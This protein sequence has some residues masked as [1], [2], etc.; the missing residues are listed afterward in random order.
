[1]GVELVDLAASP[2]RAAQIAKS[3]QFIDVGST[4]ICRWVDT[5]STIGREMAGTAPEQRQF[6]DARTF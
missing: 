1:M 6:P 3:Q 2:S 4:E 5:A